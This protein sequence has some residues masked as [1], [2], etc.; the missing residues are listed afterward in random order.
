MA[1]KI[2]TSR[3]AGTD[4]YSQRR[5]ADQRLRDQ[6]SMQ[7]ELEQTR[8]MAAE[9][10]DQQALKERLDTPTETIVQTPVEEL[11]DTMITGDPTGAETFVGTQR[12]DLGPQESIQPFPDIQVP[13]AMVDELEAA[14]MRQYEQAG[15]FPDPQTDRISQLNR[16]EIQAAAEATLTQEAATPRAILTQ[17]TGGDQLAKEIDSFVKAEIGEKDGFVNFSDMVNFAR[18]GFDSDAGSL[19]IF[20]NKIDTENISASEMDSDPQ[21]VLFRNS[22][23][24]NFALKNDRKLNLLKD[25]SDPNSGLRE[26][27][28]AAFM[29]AT[30]L[31]ISNKT[32]LMNS[33]T[34][35]L[36]D[37]EYDNA[38]D[39][40]VLGA[41]I[42][43]LAE[44]L[45]TDPEMQDPNALF[46]GASDRYGYKSKLTDDEH[47]IVGEIVLQGL[48]SANWNNL[49]QE[50]TITTPEGNTK[51]VF[52]TTRAGDAKLNAM[53]K[54]IRAKL[55]MSA[56]RDKP[57]SL[58]QTEG[59][60]MR[61]AAAFV[62]K[63]DTGGP[64]P[65]EN[66]VKVNGV[67]IV[68]EGVDALASR[69]H[70]VPMHSA[71]LYSGVLASGTQYTSNNVFSDI[72][73]QS[74]AYFQKKRAQLLKDYKDKGS[75]VDSNGNPLLTPAMLGSYF[76]VRSQRERPYRTFEEAAEFNTRQIIENHLSERKETLAD[77]FNR[78]NTTFHYGYTTINNST[79]LMITNDELNYQANKL[80]R[81]LVHGAEPVLITK[82][83]QGKDGVSGAR[84]ALN[85]AI[86]KAESNGNK[87]PGDKGY[88]KFTREEGFFR[89]IARS[90]ILGADKMTRADQLKALR[91]ELTEID[92][93]TGKPLMRLAKWGRQLLR[94]TQN[95][96]QHNTRVQQ[97]IAAGAKIPS[98]SPL[99]VTPDLQAFLKQHH[100]NDTFFFALDGL[101]ELARYLI[102]PDGGKFGTR[103]KAEVDG[104]SNGA[105]IQGYQMGVDN[106]LRK[107]G[108]L[109]Q[110]I[111]DTYETD[112][113][114][115]TLS[116]EEAE[117]LEGDIRDDVFI[118]MASQTGE[119]GKLYWGDIFNAIKANPILIKK[120]MKLPIMTSIYGKDPKH[121]KQHAR[122]F[123]NDNPELFE[124]VII[125]NGVTEA[126]LIQELREH[127]EQGLRL[128]L[129]GALEHSKMAKRIGRAHNFANEIMVTVG[130]NGAPVQSG[131]FEYVD[132]DPMLA[133]IR[134]MPITATGQVKFNFG[135]G[136]QSNRPGSPK[137]FAADISL[138]ERVPSASASAAIKYLGEGEYTSFDLGSKL[139]NQAAVNATQNIDATIAQLVVARAVKRDPTA[140]VMQIYDAFIGDANSFT[141]L[142]QTA[143][144]TFDEVNQK[145]NM[146]KAEKDSFED[147]LKRITVK[148]NQAKETGEM[149][150]LGTEGEYKALGDFYNI[151]SNGAP[152]YKTIISSDVRGISTDER[153]ALFKRAAQQMRGLAAEK[154]NQSLGDKSFKVDAEFFEQLFFA[155]IDILR[156]RPDLDK[157]IVETDARR[158]KLKKE[159][160]KRSQ[161]T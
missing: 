17:E 155:T 76:D 147:M 27:A 131:G 82:S 58:V 111:G 12:A 85:S 24:F 54:G 33:E 115:A 119:V 31:E 41:G 129:G 26:E 159:E 101:H 139:R 7:S 73:K 105:V 49:F 14:G 69:T 126:T 141:D 19:T 53:R 83:A 143:N 122:Q 32:L 116:K 30:L 96:V 135:P 121:H 110:K 29:I 81:F 9:M 1:Q 40:G 39:R 140:T 120:L 152:R 21:G 43:R 114:L 60:R 3:N 13:E 91:D 36:T 61:G 86:K 75:K 123:I 56:T 38:L 16:P 28:G 104:N 95:N 68:Q 6:E 50:Q 62:Q 15:L 47:R 78:V 2:V 103:V 151:G 11:Q 108:V 158:N 88:Q 37:R 52:K 45:M 92:P 63:R 55:G 160:R 77:G 142:E 153:N 48:A 59:G 20:G 107:G 84:R 5:Q 34:D 106:L 57:V 87:A 118:I 97:A 125:E 64:L 51:I 8:A 144:S 65:L 161:F 157:M 67:N 132:K 148:I 35:T 44:R 156:I 146:L 79:R 133:G 113:D 66:R 74:N 100:D 18:K 71:I 136:T 42:S 128:G 134:N 90:V 149:F 102:T 150:D 99:N 98:A 23:T 80:A 4:F 112:L 89:V 70:T 117:A 138:K 154:P 93:N 137:R 22:D 10:A 25:N 130:A 46:T 145:Y 124:N 72:T 127:I 94:Y 109:Y